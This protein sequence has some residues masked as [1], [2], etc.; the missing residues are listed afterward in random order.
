M[1]GKTIGNLRIVS[2]IGKGGMGVV[3]LAEHTKLGKRFA[4]KSLSPTLTQESHFR[5]RFYQEAHNQALLDH[6]NIVQATDFFDTDGQ[7]IFVMEY[8]DGQDLGELIREKGKLSVEEALP[9]F[10]DILKGL[11]FAHKKG[12]IHRDIKPSNIL[13]DNNGM[14]RI[15]DFG[16]AIL[17]GTERLTATGVAIGSPWYMS[18]EQIIH[19]QDIDHRSDVYS[20]GIV[21]YEMLTGQV[22]FDGETDYSVKNQQVN[23][24]VP[25]PHEKNP[26]I[27]QELV[28]I[29]K[30]AMQ[31]KPGDRYQGCEEFLAAIEEYEKSKLPGPPSRKWL[32]VSLAAIA[33]VSIG[34]TIYLTSISEKEVVIIPAD[35]KKNIELQHTTAFN[36][37]QSASEKALILCRELEA[38]RNK[39]EALD[40]ATNLGET[41]YIDALSTQ[42]KDHDQNIRNAISAYRDFVSQLGGLETSIVNE[43]FDKYAQAVAERKSFEQIP[44]ARSVKLHYRQETDNGQNLNLQTMRKV[45]EGK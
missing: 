23:S 45:C 29:I 36:L 22:P 13:V 26:D 31:K 44:I 15:M 16:I 5:E 37:I 21:L 32:L 40:I 18:P 33:T 27:D 39:Q 14:A 7:F 17:A 9:L 8:V 12:I 3:Y 28:Q 11:N 43:E 20:V 38:I 1:I 4:V 25:D 6:P 19:P 35:N 42:L 41:A 24:P 30:T 2:E 10:K 34:I